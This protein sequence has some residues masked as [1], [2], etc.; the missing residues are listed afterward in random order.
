ML[1]RVFEM[2]TQVGRTVEH[3]QG[4]LGIGLT[5]VRRLV[6][7][8]GGT[9]E[10][11]SDGVGQGSTFVV[12]LPLAAPL[13]SQQGRSV[14]ESNDVAGG[15]RVLI[16]DDNVDAAES[17]SMLLQINGSDTLLAHSGRAAL[18]H[19]VSFA[20]DLV[21]LDI[22]LPDLSG[23]DVAEKLRADARTSSAM[24]VALTG[25]GSDEYRKRASEVGF[26]QHLVKPVDMDQLNAVLEAA[27]KRAV[28]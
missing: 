9:I 6:E 27:K 1:T 4:G 26:D 16:V 20:P 13:E 24:L 10:A 11:A 17:L 15:V 5:L 28:R 12:R 7:L 3:A 22:G 18:E 19:A 23:Y 21:L 8:H 14:G 2:F 25:W